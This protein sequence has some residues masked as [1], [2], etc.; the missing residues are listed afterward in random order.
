MKKLI[1]LLTLFLATQAHAI[2]EFNVGY[3]GLVTSSAGGNWLVPGLSMSGG[4]GLTA[5]FTIGIPLT[6]WS[7]GVRYGKIG[8][9]GSAG[10]QT[11]SM[12]NE[13]TSLLGKYRILDTGFLL[14]GVLTYA[15]SNSGSLRNSTATP[16]TTVAAGS[17][18]QYTLGLELGIKI[19]VLLALELGYGNLS[20]SGFSGQTISGNAT[21]VSLTGP[22]AR[23]GVGFS[24]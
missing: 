23:V 19:P 7:A 18:S 21:N 2:L 1:L 16:T 9:D 14:G 20:M 22:Y 8:L 13:S 17:I 4:Y 3:Q 5:D 11:V 15:I 24:F 10:G 6:N 12:L